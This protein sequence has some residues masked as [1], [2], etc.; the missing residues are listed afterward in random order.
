VVSTETVGGVTY[1]IK[2][3]A[4]YSAAGA[5]TTLCSSGTSLAYKVVTVVVSWTGMGTVKPVRADT[6]R[7]VGVGSGAL[8]QSTLGTLAVLVSGATGS[9]REGVTVTLSP[10]GATQVSGEDGCVVFAGLT[11]GSYTAAAAMDGWSGVN[12][13]RAA[14][15]STLGVTAATVNRGTLMYDGSSR[16]DVRFDVDPSVPATATLPSGVPLLVGDS[17]VP[18]RSYPNC[19][20]PVTDACATGNPGVVAGLFPAIYTVTVGSCTSSGSRV[21]RDLRNVP[22]DPAPIVTVPVG[23]LTV[24]V[25]NPGGHWLDN[26]TVAISGQAGCSATYTTVAASGGSTILLPY[27]TWSVSVSGAAPQTVTLG[28]APNATA[29]VLFTLS[30]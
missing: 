5:S 3:S 26:R 19:S 1:T 13:T 22:A 2:Q 10:G 28:A 25:K 29:T 8:D 20:G 4:R 30:S 24:G 14:T 9:P 16:M 15:T 23:G 17:Y 7:A 6:L 21:T 18:D 11:P 27:G 12:N